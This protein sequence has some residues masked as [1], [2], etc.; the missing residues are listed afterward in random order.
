MCLLGSIA[1]LARRSGKIRSFRERKS[2]SAPGRIV[3]AKLPVECHSPESPLTVLIFSMAG[4]R[5]VA[6][7]ICTGWIVAARERRIRIELLLR[8]GSTLGEPFSCPPTDLAVPMTDA[9]VL[10]CLWE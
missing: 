8:A 5:S 1:F 2:S 6:S 9:A 4:S 7:A 10:R 3:E